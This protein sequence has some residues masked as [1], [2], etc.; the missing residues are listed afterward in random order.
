MRWLSVRHSHSVMARQ[1]LRIGIISKTHVSGSCWWLSIETSA[2]TVGQDSCMWP[3]PVAWSSSQPGDW[4]PRTGILEEAKEKLY[5]CLLRSHTVAFLLQSVHWK[6]VTT[7]RLYSREGGMFKNLWACG[8][9]HTLV[10]TGAWP[11]VFKT[12]ILLTL[13][14]KS[15]SCRGLLSA[16]TRR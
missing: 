12:T 13:R 3:L 11:V 10:V 6:W 9:H 16:P 15:Y 2:V 7:V 14:K 1:R 8:S 5:C 4:V